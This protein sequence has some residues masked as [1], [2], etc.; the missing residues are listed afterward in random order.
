MKHK[1]AYLVLG[2]G[3]I[4]G[5]TFLNP[6]RHGPRQ[7]VPKIVYNLI[8]EPLYMSNQ[9]CSSATVQITQF[10][11]N[12]SPDILD[13]IQIWGIGRPDNENNIVVVEKSHSPPTL[14]TR[15]I[16]LLIIN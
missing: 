10:C 1:R 4:P 16:V 15:S 12:Y 5:Q 2:T 8:P 6:S 13:G 3:S 7:L 11:F 14:V 9:F